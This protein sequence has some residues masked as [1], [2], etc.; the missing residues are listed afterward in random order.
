MVKQLGY[1][2]GFKVRHICTRSNHVVTLH[3]GSLTWE[4][5]DMHGG[6]VQQFVYRLSLSKQDDMKQQ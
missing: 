2:D 1:I 4:E 6:S 5:A 3:T